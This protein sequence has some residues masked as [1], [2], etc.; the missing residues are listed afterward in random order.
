MHCN[1][2]PYRRLLLVFETQPQPQQQ[3]HYCNK[4]RSG[5]D[6]SAVRCAVRHQSGWVLRW[7]HA[8]PHLFSAHVY[9]RPTVHSHS[10]AGILTHYTSTHA[11]THAR[12][13]WLLT[14]GGIP[15]VAGVTVGRTADLVLPPDGK[16]GKK[17]T[18]KKKN[19][20]Y[21]GI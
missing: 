21:S 20:T 8:P 9:L 12:R 6:G 7:P 1:E 3:R 14:E 4:K 2:S 5:G 16:G 17:A 13:A 11:R 15:C 19:N 10:N 18:K